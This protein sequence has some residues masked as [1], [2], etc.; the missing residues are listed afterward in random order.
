MYAAIATRRAVLAV[1][2]D[3]AFV[4]WVALYL[5]IN[6]ADLVTTFIGLQRGGTEI[7]PT[8]VLAFRFSFAVGIAVK[9]LFA[10]AFLAWA[11]FTYRWWRA[12]AFAEVVV[13]CAII[14]W[15][16]AANLGWVPQ[17]YGVGQ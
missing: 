3:R 5:A 13:M 7:T 12:L 14:A 2:R 8:Y 17:L 4:A 15:I 11:I 1:V 16:V 6:V 9:L 10:V